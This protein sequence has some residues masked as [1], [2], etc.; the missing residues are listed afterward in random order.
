M[1]EETIHQPRRIYAKNMGEAKT[2]FAR[3]LIDNGARPKNIDYGGDDFL[4]V[5]NNIYPI[6][7]I[8]AVIEYLT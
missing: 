7:V 4:K 1:S 8:H 5:G 6:I 2:L 3:I